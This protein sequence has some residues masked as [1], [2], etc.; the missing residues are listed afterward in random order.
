MYV[1]V[2]ILIKLN[3]ERSVVQ[4]YVIQKGMIVVER[5]LVEKVITKSV[6]R[7]MAVMT[8]G[9]VGHVWITRSIVV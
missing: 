1:S 6:V 5:Q 2:M 7:Q 9:A 8:M 3:V 4:A